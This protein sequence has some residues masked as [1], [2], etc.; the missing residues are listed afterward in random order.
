MCAYLEYAICSFCVTLLS[1]VPTDYRNPFNGRDVQ[2][3][4]HK[5]PR[6][7]TATCSDSERLGII[8]T[9]YGGPGVPDRD[10]SFA[11][12]ARIQ[13]M[14]GNRHDIISFDQRGLGHSQP[15]VNCFGSALKYE[16]FKTNTVLETTFETCARARRDAGRR[17]CRGGW[18]RGSLCRPSRVVLSDSSVSHSHLSLRVRHC[19]PALRARCGQ[20]ERSRARSARALQT[21]PP[22]SSPEADADPNAPQASPVTP[23]KLP[24][25]SSVS[26]GNSSRRPSPLC[27]SS[28]PRAHVPISFKFLVCIHRS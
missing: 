7:T 13:D 17:L 3:C 5:V 24:L 26:R 4:A 11:S 28:E 6:H 15:K 23:F 25:R 22:S 10:A 9:N 2:T 12:G 21:P 27:S 16:Q 20:S 8:I 1:S 19:A 18:R 14:T